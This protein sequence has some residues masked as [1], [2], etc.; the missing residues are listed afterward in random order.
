MNTGKMSDEAWKLESHEV[1][2]KRR[3]FQT[4]GTEYVRFYEVGEYNQGQYHQGKKV[5]WDGA[6]G[7][8]R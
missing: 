1:N 4:E 5:D 2:K 8:W 7:K 3:V 6:E